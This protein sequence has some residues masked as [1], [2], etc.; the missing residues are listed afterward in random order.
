MERFRV[1]NNVRP[2]T[3][4]QQQHKQQQ[5][6]Q[7]QDGNEWLFGEKQQREEKNEDKMQA[8]EERTQ[9]KQNKK[10]NYT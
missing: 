6:Q 5:Q 2:S 1:E 8:I 10:I 3:P 7:H 9:T 4:Q